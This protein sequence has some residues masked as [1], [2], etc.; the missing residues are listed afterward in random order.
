MRFTISSRKLLL[1]ISSAAL[2]G[3]CNPPP[4]AENDSKNMTTAQLNE[5]SVM[6][7]DSDTATTNSI[8]Q[9]WTGP[10]DGVPAWDKVKVSDFPGAF[11]AIMDKVKSQVN[12]V[13]DNPAAATFENFTL[14]ME[15]AGNSGDELFAIWGVHSSNL[16]NEEVRKIQGEWLPKISAFFILDC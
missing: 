6:Q 10:Y 8:L 13:R 7:A 2:F 9:T 11:Q 3:A 4:M 15:L 1:G 12:A 14:P 5:A 16:S